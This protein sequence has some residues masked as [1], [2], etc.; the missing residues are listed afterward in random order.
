MASAS[1]PTCRVPL[2]RSPTSNPVAASNSATNL[3]YRDKESWQR[4][5]SGSSPYDASVIGASMPAA[6]NEAPEP[7][8]SST[9]VTDSPRWTQRQAMPS[10]IRP[11]PA[12]TTSTDDDEAV[13]TR[14]R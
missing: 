10:P 4:R 2:V 8:S 14:P 6:A 1:N 7:K 5:S 13:M 9:T 3:G 12:T 11:P